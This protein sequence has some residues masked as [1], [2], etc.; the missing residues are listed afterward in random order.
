MGKPALY[1]YKLLYM[2]A[3]TLKP[4]AATSQHPFTNQHNQKS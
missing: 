4:N 2:C 3:S 1:E